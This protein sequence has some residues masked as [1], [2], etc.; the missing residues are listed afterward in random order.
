VTVGTDNVAVDFH[1]GRPAGEVSF[2]WRTG[3]PAGPSVS[4]S[5]VPAAGLAPLTVDFAGTGLAGG[6]YSWDFADGNAGTGPAPSASF[7]GAGLY[8][9]VL[10]GV[11]ATGVGR[12]LVLVAVTD[13]AFPPAGLAAPADGALHLAKGS[14]KR[15]PRVPGKD[16]AT[17]SAS[18]EVPGGF[19][20]LGQEV[21]VCVAGAIRTFT[22]D[23]KGKGALP[24]GSKV[25]LKAKWPKDG[26]GVPAG[27]IAK[28]AATLKGDLSVP[29]DAAGLRDRTETRAIPGVP[30]AVLLAGRP[31]VAAGTLTTKAVEGRT[32]KGTLV[33]AE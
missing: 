8:P 11:D 24:D 21:R 3:I 14:A 16:Q 29:L 23:A 26:S 20:P 9:V 30:A 7:A 32:G 13:P 15:N 33:P 28:I 17:L 5:A 4:A 18:L 25:A 2:G 1:A 10:S 6:V 19:A 12:A 31:W 27:T 22:L